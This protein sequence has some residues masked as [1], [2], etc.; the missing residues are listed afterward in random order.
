MT[1]VN[2]VITEVP[3]S[4]PSLQPLSS[5]VDRTT[6]W[7]QPMKVR[8]SCMKGTSVHYAWYQHAH[9]KDFL[10]Y[11]SSDLYLHCG[12]VEKDSDY[13]C[14]ASN[15]VSSQRSDVLSV[16]VLMPADPNCIYVVYTRGQPIYDCADRMSTTTFQTPPLTSCQAIGKILPDTR[17]QS[18]P[19][20]K[21][22][23]DL[24]FFRAWT[25]VPLWYSFVR[26]S[27]FAFLLIF[28]GVVLKC[29]K[30]RQKRVKRKRR[31]CVRRRHQLAH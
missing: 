1:S 14:V 20:N 17:N 5:L 13:Y 6:C 30:A 2:V 27:C 4:K 8:C 21:T 16:Q 11:Q 19:N 18:S 9:H 7:G 24:F 10:L 28:L 23:Q 26:W 29:S 3:V 31:V 25:G 15:D 12:S 22:D